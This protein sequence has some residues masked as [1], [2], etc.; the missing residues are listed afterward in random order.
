MCSREKEIL[1][2]MFEGEVVPQQR[3]TSRHHAPNQQH[4]HRSPVLSFLS[5]TNFPTHRV[6]HTTYLLFSGEW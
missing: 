4:L 1:Y 2:L 3:T 5:H 6:T